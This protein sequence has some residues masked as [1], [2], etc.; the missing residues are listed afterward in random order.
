MIWKIIVFLG[1]LTNVSLGVH[2]YRSLVVAS[3][4]FQD[5]DAA[6]AIGYAFPRVSFWDKR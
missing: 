6:R 4:E 3:V 2:L 5:V 1:C